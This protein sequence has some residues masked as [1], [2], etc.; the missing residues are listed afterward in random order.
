M[1][2]IREQGWCDVIPPLLT[3]STAHDQRE[4]TLRAMTTLLG[5]CNQAFL[6]SMSALN[7]LEREYT[8]LIIDEKLHLDSK[9]EEERELE[10]D[11]YFQSMLDIVEQLRNDL[12][13]LQHSHSEL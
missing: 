12:S 9:T 13:S 7:S 1:D 11:G 4:K 5:V 8:A 6:P 2:H 10:S 3:S